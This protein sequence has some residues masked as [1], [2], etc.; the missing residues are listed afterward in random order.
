MAE[1]LQN[2]VNDYEQR[3]RRLPHVPHFSY[4]RTM[5]RDDG[6][7]NK[8]FLIYLFTDNVMAI[9]F[10]QKVGLL[11]ST[12]LCN[13]CHRDMTWFAA[14]GVKDWFRWRCHRRV[15]GVKCEQSASINHSI[16]F[17]H[18]D[19]GAH[20]NTIEST[21]HHVKVF[22]GPLN[23]GC[24]FRVLHIYGWRG[25]WHQIEGY[26]QFPYIPVTAR[27]LWRVCVPIDRSV[28]VP[29]SAEFNFTTPF[30]NLYL[31]ISAYK[32]NRNNEQR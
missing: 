3:V 8:F 17:V 22:L 29:F 24:G 5:L 2:I 19:T 26:Q 10:L 25:L 31:F 1:I 11:R 21:W 9:E 32:E 23:R 28:S 4:R 13:N 14:S 27:E 16:Q 20:T 6:A 12:M 7:P 18:P 15:A 30:F